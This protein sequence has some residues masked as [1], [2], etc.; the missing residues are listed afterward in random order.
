MIKQQPD[1]GR[2]VIDPAAEQQQLSDRY[3]P[4]VAT[5]R[6][7]ER[8]RREPSTTPLIV[9]AIGAVLGAVLYA[10]VVAFVAFTVI[11][12]AFLAAATMPQ[13]KWTPIDSWFVLGVVVFTLWAAGFAFYRLFLDLRNLNT[14]RAHNT[15]RVS[16]R[17]AGFVDFGDGFD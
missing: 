15:V 14:E 9:S 5:G 17:P 12:S 4:V 1:S 13:A 8:T 10:I 6:S 3:G 11:A 7:E 2:P 16:D